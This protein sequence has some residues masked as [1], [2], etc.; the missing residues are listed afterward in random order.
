MGDIN[1][2]DLE[3]LVGRVLANPV[4]VEDSEASQSTT[5]TFLGDG[6]EVSLWLLLFDGTG[7]LWFTIGTSLGNWPLNLRPTRSSA[8]DW[9]F[10]SGFCCLT[11]PELFGLPYGHPLAT[12]LFLPPRLMAMR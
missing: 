11:A 3:V 1:H 9:R 6:L 10:L 8:M 7:A 5:N 4:R 12:G 2:D